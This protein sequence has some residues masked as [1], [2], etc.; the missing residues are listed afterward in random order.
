MRKSA[1][2]GVGSVAAT[3]VGV[4]TVR[5]TRT[6]MT[7]RAMNIGAEEGILLPTLHSGCGSH[8]RARVENLW[9]AG[10]NLVE[11][12]RAQIFF[13]S[14]SER[15]VR[16]PSSGRRLR[17]PLRLIICH[18]GVKSSPFRSLLDTFLRTTELNVHRF[19]KTIGGRAYQIEVRPVSNRWRA[20]L[21]LVPGR[22]AAMMPFYG[23]TPDEAA[24]HLAEWLT[25]AHRR[26]LASASP[27]PGLLLGS[28]VSPGR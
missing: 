14:D 18:S 25:L 24:A 12:L 5:Q 15:N 16:T 3:A 6:P 13:A 26:R 9:T 10:A 28:K 1:T 19:D 27:S 7:K 4:A 23:T 17:D 8:V 2:S 22:T 20:Q 21:R 11:K